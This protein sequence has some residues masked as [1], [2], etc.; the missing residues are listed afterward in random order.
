MYAL[1]QLLAS[2]M[3]V[4][5]LHQVEYSESQLNTQCE[6]TSTDLEPDYTD[7]QACEIGIIYKIDVGNI[8][9]GDFALAP[10]TGI[11]PP[12]RNSSTANLLFS[13]LLPHASKWQSL[14]LAL[15]LDDDRIDEILTNNE[16]DEACLQE[17][18]EHYMMRSD[19][20]HSWEEIEA[21]LERIANGEFDYMNN[22]IITRTDF[23]RIILSHHCGYIQIPLV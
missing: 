1:P 21:A 8:I 7:E 15:S 12:H 4:D 17:M 5:D 23:S 13:H 3:V 2:K 16:T 9:H 19:S 18:L 10:P 6:I 20:N 11:P 22:I 14:G